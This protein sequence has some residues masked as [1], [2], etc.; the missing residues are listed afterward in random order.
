MRTRIAVGIVA[1]LILVACEVPRPELSPLTLASPLPRVYL[2]VVARYPIDPRQGVS[3][4]FFHCEDVATLK[5]NWFHDWGWG[6]C[7][8]SG[9]YIDTIWGTQ[10][11]TGTITG[12]TLIGFNEPDLENQSNIAPCEA[13]ILWRQIEISYTTKYLISPVPSQL[14]PQWLWGMVD[15]YSILNGGARPRFDAVQ[16]HY[17]FWYG[18]PTLDEYITQLRSDMAAHGYAGKPIWVTE[19]GTCGSSAD[20]ATWMRGAIDWMQTQTDIARWAWY[21]ARVSPT[22]CP[23]NLVN[24]D[25]TPN[26]LGI[27]YM[28]AGK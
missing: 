3:I 2:P 7:E 19:F 22:E 24:A 28:E 25:G 14:N 17:Y 16:A 5:A 26:A 27:A 1:Y 23:M 9:E 13:A 18:Q 21:S 8:N 10:G 15:C 20:P 6:R 4:Q 12:S 11:I